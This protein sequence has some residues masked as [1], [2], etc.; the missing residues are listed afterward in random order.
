[1]SVVPTGSAGSMIR[2]DTDQLRAVA[3]QMHATADQITSGTDG[4]RQSM[5]ALDA[6]WSGQAHDRGMARWGEILPKYPPAVERLVHFAN[7][8]EALAQRLDDAAAAFGGGGSSITAQISNMMRENIEAAIKLVKGWHLGPD[9]TLIPMPDLPPHW[10]PAPLP[11]PPAIRPSWPIGPSDGLFPLPT[12]PEFPGLGP[13]D[14]LHPLPTLPN[15]PWPTLPEPLFPDGLPGGVH[16]LPEPLFPDGLPGGIHTLPEP[17]GPLHPGGTPT[18]LELMGNHDR[19]NNLGYQY[20][21]ID[22]GIPGT[23]AANQIA[24]S[25]AASNLLGTLPNSPLPGSFSWALPDATVDRILA[26][27]NAGSAPLAA[28]A[29][30]TVIAGAQ[31]AVAS[32]SNAGAS[33][34]TAGNETASTVVATA[35]ANAAGGNLLGT[36]QGKLPF[37]SFG[38]ASRP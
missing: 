20:G 3:R 4:M 26:N 31:A 10:P 18:L 34:L 30:A 32:A 11:W 35:A 6:T 1:M 24:T 2:A 12:V 14:G 17:I 22:M 16:T 8:L 29:Q 13:S 21:V 27:A 33:A 15:F 7:E 9:G 23:Q 38:G 36:I 25:P 5:D 19:P 28:G 37:L